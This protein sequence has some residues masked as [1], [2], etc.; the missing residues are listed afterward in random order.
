MEGLRPILQLRSSSLR[1]DDTHRTS[2]AT[3]G[4]FLAT[5]TS[6]RRSKGH[7]STFFSLFGLTDKSASF[8][9]P[10]LVGLITQ[11]TGDIGYAFVL[12]MAMMILPLPL[13]LTVDVGEAH[14]QAKRWGSVGE[15]REREGERLLGEVLPEAPVLG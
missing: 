1:T 5:L 10:L 12:I 11:L 7:E 2:H 13:L 6:D 8:A 15:E 4:P 14:E 3:F 9:G